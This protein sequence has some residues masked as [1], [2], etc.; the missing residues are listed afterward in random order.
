[1]TIDVQSE[2]EAFLDVLATKAPPHDISSTQDYR[3]AAM[4][5]DDSHGPARFWYP[6]DNST[7]QSLEQAFLEAA[8]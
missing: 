5:Q 2:F 8:R 7:S 3:K 4:D 1:M 6:C